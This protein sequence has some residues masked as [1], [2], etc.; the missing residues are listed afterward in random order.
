MSMRL[1]LLNEM[2][3]QFIYLLNSTKMASKIELL[4]KQ[5]KK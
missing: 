1:L 3:Y 2:V 5:N 4:P